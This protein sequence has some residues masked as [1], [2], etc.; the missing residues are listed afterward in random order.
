MLNNVGSSNIDGGKMNPDN[1]LIAPKSSSSWTGRKWAMF[2]DVEQNAVNRDRWIQKN[3]YY[4]QHDINFLNF[5]TAKNANILDVGCGNGWLLSKL[6]AAKKTGVDFSPA[7]ID[8]AEEIC[9]DANFIL[10]D[11]ES[12]SMLKAI[13]AQGPF[14]YII[15]SDTLAYLDD[16][17]VTLAN[18]KSLCSPSTR[19]IM[20]TYN[21][22]WEPFLKL[23][24]M[25]GLKQLM[26]FD[27]NWISHDD[28][29]SFCALTELEI[30]TKEQHQLVPFR[31]FGL[32]HFLNKWLSPLP[33]IRSLCLRKYVVARPVPPR[34]HTKPT[35]SVIVPVRNE[36]GNIEA[37]LT[38]LSKFPAAMELIYVEG[39]SSDN[40]WEEIQ[41][42]QR[43]YPDVDI[44]ALKQPGKG[45]GDA[46]HHAFQQAKGDILM[47]LDGDLTVPPEDMIKFYNVLA[48]GVGEFV[49]GTR[50]VYGM[51]KNAMRFLNYHANRTFALIF[52]YLLNQQFTDTL[53]GTKVMFR[54]DYEK[55][56][57]NKSFF[58][59]FDPFGDFDFIFGAVKLHLK[60]VEV[61][62]RY[63]AR[64]YG[65]TQ[66]SRFRHGFM[67]LKMVIF[68]FKKLKAI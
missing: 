2:D 23:G 7:M 12:R 17:E 54:S 45:K 37:A 55:I 1:K 27:L 60:V 61:P 49:N 50:L 36:A 3:S 33:L 26:R 52:S 39:N 24:E 66:I 20:S 31:L 44:T 9:P 28:L 58:G 46:V 64:T 47:I 14:D 63:R 8:C 19:I 67:L 35:V 18:I 15:L 25:I 48:S 65:S 29:K 13:K 53:C 21:Q 38:R 51:E 6:N 4:H 56:L 32:G 62:V 41:R 16:I 43:D 22:L 11:I 57:A 30:L 10:A 59:D 42:M 5:L 68:A 34:R 40:S